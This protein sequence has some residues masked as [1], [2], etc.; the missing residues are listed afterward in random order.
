MYVDC[1]NCHDILILLAWRCMNVSSCIFMYFCSLK[2]NN[3]WTLIH[4]YTFVFICLMSMD[5]FCIDFYERSCMHMQQI[6]A[7]IG[8]GAFG[9]VYQ[10]FNIDTGDFV[11]MKRFPI[12][13]IDNDQLSSIEV[14]RCNISF[15]VLA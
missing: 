2:H 10:A 3:L 12:K 6:G 9:V 5:E 15:I 13:S 7:E 14:S 8:R 1:D 11:A 4:A